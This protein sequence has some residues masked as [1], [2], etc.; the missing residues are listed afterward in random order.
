LDREHGGRAA[1]MR[2]LVP[3]SAL[4]LTRLHV[5]PQSAA[6]ATPASVAPFLAPLLAMST[7]WKWTAACAALATLGFLATRELAERPR[8]SAA[9]VAD[10]PVPRA[11]LEAPARSEL[12]AAAVPA[13]ESVV[14]EPAR[15]VAAAEASAAPATVAQPTLVGFV[16]DLEQRP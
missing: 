10:A 4:P 12:D 1:W 2:M 16:R 6:A 8:A 9:Q 3:A 7:L 11:T 5:P 14:A 13:R 15:P